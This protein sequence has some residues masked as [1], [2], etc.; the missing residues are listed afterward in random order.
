MHLFYKIYLLSLRVDFKSIFLSRVHI[1]NNDNDNNNNNNNN[2]NLTYPAKINQFV[3]KEKHADINTCAATLGPDYD[4]II[5][6]L[7][8]KWVHI[9]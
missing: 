9:N 1:N 8:I 5:I 3:L 6:E 4:R 2:Y 7:K